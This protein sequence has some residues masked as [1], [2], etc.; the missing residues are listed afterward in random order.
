MEQY[1]IPREKIRVIPMAPVT[2]LYPR[3]TAEDL[4]TVQR[5]FALP[6]TFALYPA[7]TWPH[8]NHI[9]LLKAVELLVRNHELD[10]HLVCSG[11]K[12]DFFPRIHEEMHRLGIAQRV[13]FVGF[14]SPLELQCLYRLCRMM[15]FPS[16]FEGWGLPLTE[17]FHAGV[18]VASSNATC[19]PEL[20]LDAALLFDP[21]DPLQIATAMKQLWTD[22]RL[23]HELARRGQSYASRLSWDRTARMFRAYYRD[24]AGRGITQEDRDLIADLEDCAEVS[25]TSLTT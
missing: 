9:N 23:R 11:T 21:E 3:P 6:E 4:E 10:I 13:R 5:K 18:P 19:L 7:Q 2:A 1:Q 17:A 24:L 14:V 12:N 15:V 16:K 8:K 25:A 22:E 20:A